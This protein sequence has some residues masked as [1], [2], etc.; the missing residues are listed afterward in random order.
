MARQPKTRQPK[1]KFAKRCM[2]CKEL[3]VQRVVNGVLVR[4][5]ACKR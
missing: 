2:T 5:C 3:V 1:V 4:Y